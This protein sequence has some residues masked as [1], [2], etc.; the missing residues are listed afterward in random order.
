[1][2]N[3]E[4]YGNDDLCSFVIRVLLTGSECQSIGYY[5]VHLTVS[6]TCASLQQQYYNADV[7][8]LSITAHCM[9]QWLY[10]HMWI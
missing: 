6:H 4:L 3:L 8:A 5:S 2:F 9:N 10:L 1:M 7:L